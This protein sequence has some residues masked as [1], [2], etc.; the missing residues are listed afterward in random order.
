MDALQGTALH[1]STADYDVAV[2][3]RVNG[4]WWTKP[5]FAQPRVPIQLDGRW[6]TTIV[7]G[8][9]DHLATDIAAFLVPKTYSPPALSGAATLP[10]ALFTNAAATVQTA[11]NSNGIS[12]VVTNALGNPLTGVMLSLSGVQSATTTSVPDGKYS[13]PNLT[14]TGPYTVTPSYPGYLFMP[15]ACNVT[16]AS[17][18]RTCTFTG[19]LLAQ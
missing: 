8:G 11:R 3:I 5:T 16:G 4:G 2:Y 19:S 9:S 10:A 6:S 18:N 17:G 7:T 1:V 12:G 15:A 14:S 13:F